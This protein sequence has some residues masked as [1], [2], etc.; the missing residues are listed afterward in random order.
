MILAGFQCVVVA[1][2]YT[3]K[4]ILFINESQVLFRMGVWLIIQFFS[5]FYGGVTSYV[6]I[7]EF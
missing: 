5:S 6:A 7:M 3:D 2:H 1:S 4:S